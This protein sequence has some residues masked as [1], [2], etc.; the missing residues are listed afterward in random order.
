MNILINSSKTMIATPAHADL[1]KPA[2]LKQAK[3]LDAILKDYSAPELAKLMH[4]SPKLA[5]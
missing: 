2:L 3:Q 4:L 1:Q 5:G